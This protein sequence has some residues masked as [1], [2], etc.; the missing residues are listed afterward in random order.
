[1]ITQ[2]GAFLVPMFMTKCSLDDIFVTHSTGKDAIQDDLNPVRLSEPIPGETSLHPRQND[3]HGQ[4]GHK[5]TDLRHA[6][7]VHMPPLQEEA[8]GREK[9]SPAEDA[10]SRPE[11]SDGLTIATHPCSS[12]LSAS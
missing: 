1:M 8:G 5:E 7:A 4:P 11:D 12:H 3:Q 9:R 2:E 6:V 10:H